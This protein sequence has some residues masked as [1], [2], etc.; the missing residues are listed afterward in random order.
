MMQRV[1]AILTQARAF[2]DRYDEIEAEDGSDDVT[3]ETEMIGEFIVET[4]QPGPVQTPTD[5]PQD[6]ADAV[7]GAMQP[8]VGVLLSCFT[9]AFTELSV[10][11]DEAKGDGATTE[12]LRELALRW[13]LEDG[14]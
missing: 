10:R 5:H 13:E 14:E 6:V 12:L 7:V 1:V 8:R 9:A 11:Y 3:P 2:A 4:L